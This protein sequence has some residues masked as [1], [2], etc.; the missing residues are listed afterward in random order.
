MMIEKKAKGEG[1]AIVGIAMAVVMLA[2]V[3]AVMVPMSEART[4]ATEIDAGDTVYIGEQ[5]LALDLN[6]DGIYG[7]VGVLEGVPDTA[8]EGTALSVPTSWIVP[9][10]TEGKY[11][12]DANG[13]G[14]LDAGE[15]YIYVDTPVIY[16]DVI[17]NTATQDSIVGKSVPETSEIVFKIETNFGGRI[18]GACVDIRLID[19]DGV[20]ICELDEQTL[21]DTEVLGTTMFV[22]NPAPTITA[23][24]YADALGLADLYMGEYTVKFKTDKATCNML[25]VSSPEYEFTVRHEELSIDVAKDTVYRGEDVVLTVTGNP[26]TYYYLIV[27]NVDVTAPPE[28]K[29]VEGVKALDTAGDAY[30]ATATPN[31]AAWIKTGSDDIAKVI[32]ATIGADEKTYTIKV[33]DATTP[34]YPDFVPDYVV[35]SEDDDDVDVKVVKPAVAFD[36]PASAVIGERVTIRGTVSAGDYVDIVIKDH[37]VVEDDEAVDLN[38]EFEVKWDT[39]GYT[40][41]LYTIEAYIDCPIW[42]WDPDAY[43]V[44][45]ADGSTMIVLV[46]P[47]LTAEQPQ[48]VVAEDDDY[49]IEGTATGTDEVDIVLVGPKGYPAVDL[50]L[51]VLN[52]L[53]IM[54]SSVTNDEFSEDITMMDGVDTGTWKTMVFSPGRDGVYGNTWLSAG[55]LDGIGTAVFAGKTQ[56][57]IVAILKDYTIDVAGSDDL[58]VS[59]TFEVETPYVRFDPIESVTIGE[60]LKITG[61]TNR[62][63]GTPIAIWTIE[64]PKE[65]PPVI[66]NVEWPTPYQGIFNATINTSDAVLGTYTLE[67][68]DGDGNNDTATVEILPVISIFDTGAGTYP[69]IFGT[70]D[71][72][73]TPYYD[74]NVCKIHT[75]S[76]SGTGGHTEYVA[77]YNATTREEIANG[78]WNGYQGAGDYHYI[79]FDSPFVLQASVTYNYTIRTG[80]YPQ[81]IH[82]HSKEVTG[83]VINCTEFTDANGKK[84]NNWIPA[85]RLE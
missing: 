42:G 51:G 2:S 69:S 73:I 9:D 22:G 19:P 57:Q 80:S 5:G 50:G 34:V 44:I 49:T 14:A 17:L 27:T 72:T 15:F 18:P 28:I 68:N 60:P 10:V 61:K 16:G 85:I 11:Y 48:N 70:H 64:G 43:N 6:S 33:Y 32:I 7:D 77:F 45:D 65:L 47:G 82:A 55:N 76:C 62:E 58:L 13:N 23:P 41:G 31:L 67:A 53:A 54:S 24:P 36:I 52:G 30:P 83:G 1:K 26:I 4:T 74:I 3:L 79:A 8:T 78:T 39:S 71:G 35:V 12:Y 25:D 84:Y 20:M 37:E 59:F 29:M 46:E 56:S 21:R 40:K 38:K 81:I 63:P 75:Y 66:T